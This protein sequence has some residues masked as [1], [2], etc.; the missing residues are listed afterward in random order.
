[1]IGLRPDDSLND[2][3]EQIE[4]ILDG[5]FVNWRERQVFRR[6][7]VVSEATGALDLPGRTWRDR[8]R[9]QQRDNL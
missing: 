7:A 8:P 9:I 2:G 4:Q 5:G 3:I 1:M 6:R